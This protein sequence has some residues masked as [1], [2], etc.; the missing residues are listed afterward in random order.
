MWRVILLAVLLVGCESEC[1]QVECGCVIEVGMTQEQE[2]CAI[3]AE[4]GYAVGWMGEDGVR[5]VQA[6]T[7]M[8]ANADTGWTQVVVGQCQ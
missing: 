6:G 7:V 8:V 5:T 1:E 2:A 3:E 4:Y